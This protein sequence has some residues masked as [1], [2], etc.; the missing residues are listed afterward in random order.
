MKL[1]EKRNYY[2]RKHKT[3]RALFCTYQSLLDQVES[4]GVVSVN[5]G[6][7]TSLAKKV[8]ILQSILKDLKREKNK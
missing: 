2:R 5:F 7:T 8:N 1:I 4:Q 3:N 6:E